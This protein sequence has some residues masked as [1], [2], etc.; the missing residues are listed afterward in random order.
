MAFSGDGTKV[1]SGSDDETVRVWDV[2]S[3]E[4]VRTLTGHSGWV[5]MGP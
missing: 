5:S 2:G 4:C 1:V 3:G